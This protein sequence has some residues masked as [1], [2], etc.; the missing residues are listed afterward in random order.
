M[1]PNRLKIKTESKTLVIK[2]PVSEVGSNTKSD[3]AVNH[4]SLKSD[5]AY[6]K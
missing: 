2:R 1:K 5:M 6:M 3:S 4:K